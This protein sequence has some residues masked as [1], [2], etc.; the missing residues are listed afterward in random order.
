MEFSQSQIVERSKR[1][2]PVVMTKIIGNSALLPV[3]QEMEAR[4]ERV[5]AAV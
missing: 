3:A 4:F 5:I 2:L 1:I